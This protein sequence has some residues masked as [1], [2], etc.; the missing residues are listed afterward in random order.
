MFWFHGDRPIQLESTYALKWDWLIN[1]LELAASFRYDDNGDT[2]DESIF[3]TKVAWRRE[4]VD[5]TGEY[6][7]DK[8]YSPDITDEQRKVNLKMN[9]VF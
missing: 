4:N 2:F 5:V 1:D 7:F 3:N 6:Q 9:V 8:T